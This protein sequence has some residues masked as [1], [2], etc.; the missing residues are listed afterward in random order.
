MHEEKRRACRGC[1]RFALG[2]VWFAFFGPTRPTMC[3]TPASTL[4][5]G[6]P[7]AI[8][9]PPRR[10][11]P[12]R[13]SNPP[14]LQ[15]LACALQARAMAAKNVGSARAGGRRGGARGKARVTALQFAPFLL[16][17]ISPPPSSSPPLPFLIRLRLWLLTRWLFLPLALSHPRRSPA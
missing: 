6:C 5:P 4:E 8:P 14:F 9:P 13:R 15:N 1:R 2:R 7:D 16:V 11:H 12:Q 10:L 3:S 17:I